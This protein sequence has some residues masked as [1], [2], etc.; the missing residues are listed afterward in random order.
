MAGVPGDAKK[1]VGLSSSMIA[2]MESQVEEMR[3]LLL[4]FKVAAA[5]L[6]PVPA[7]SPSQPQGGAASSALAPPSHADILVFGPSGS[8]KSS[9][10]R[11]FFM[12]LHKT[13][14]VPK[15]F[16]DRIIVK[17]TAMNEGTLKYVSAVIKPAKV[18][19]RGIT[20]SSAIMCH[21]TRGHIWM[22]EREQKQ[23][24]IMLDGTVRDDSL[25]QQRNY[26]YA[27]LLWEFWRKDADLFPPEI[28]VR[29]PNIQTQPHALLFVFDG[30]MEEIPDGEQETQFYREIIA[31]ARQK[32]Y[33]Y[34]QVVLT[35]IDRV[36][37]SLAKSNGSVDPG[38]AELRLRQVLDNKIENVVMKLDVSRSSVHF[39]EN[40]HSSGS[41]AQGRNVSVDFHALKILTQCCSHAD[42]FVAQSLRAQKPA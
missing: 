12:S 27:R 5:D 26:R 4:R 34:P 18:D 2:I 21:D 8:G 11:T 38:E 13:Q 7:G 29:R 23:L 33:S 37:E 31:M 14:E 6:P 15:D 22:D 19:H 30:S 28:L 42:A 36:E 17:D 35:R 20:T 9:L 32:G 41:W 40:Y 25:V 3:R 16:A 24:S 39:I 1:R 10:I